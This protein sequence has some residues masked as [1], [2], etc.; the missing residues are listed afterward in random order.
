MNPKSVTNEVGALF[1]RKKTVYY[2]GSTL[3]KYFPELVI[4]YKSIL[5]DFGIA[6][7]VDEN[8]NPGWALW[9]MGLHEQ[10]EKHKTTMKAMIKKKNIK[11]II[12]SSPEALYMFH[13]F[14]PEI[15]AFHTTELIHQNREKIQEFNAGEASWHDNTTQVR[16]NNIITQGRDIL[17]ASG[18]ILKEFT[19]N[20]RETQCLGTSTGLLNNSPRLA[21][22]LALRRVRMAPTKLIITDSPEDYLTLRRNTGANVKEISEVLVEI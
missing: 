7:T 8:L 16:R 21:E 15:T 2:P 9:E 22:K 19:E 20:K 13:T 4:N 11:T 1:S 14:Y 5:A 12:T 10:F 18:F 17:I 3:S 6:I